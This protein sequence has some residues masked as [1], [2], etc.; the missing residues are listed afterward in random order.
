MTRSSKRYAKAR[1]HLA[2]D[3]TESCA[4]D[5]VIRRLR[6]WNKAR[7][8]LGDNPS[9]SYD[10]LLSLLKPTQTSLNTLRKIAQSFDN[11]LQTVMSRHRRLG[12]PLL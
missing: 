10:A 7:E 11:Q 9:Y 3:K 8:Y 4:P 12:V 5:L 6:A 1:K 2:L